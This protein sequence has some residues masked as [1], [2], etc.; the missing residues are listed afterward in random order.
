MWAGSISKLNMYAYMDMRIKNGYTCMCIHNHINRYV[1]KHTCIYI[2][3]YENIYMY[4]YIWY[5]YMYIHNHMNIYIYLYIYISIT[6]GVN[7]LDIQIIYMPMKNMLD[8][9][10]KI[11]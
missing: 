7:S 10:S 1:Y 3:I 8:K 4:M 2:Y 11:K 6:T 9:H 5:T